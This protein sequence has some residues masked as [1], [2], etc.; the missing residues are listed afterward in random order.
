MNRKLLIFFFLS[1]VLEGSFGFKSFECPMNSMSFTKEQDVNWYT[2]YENVDS[3]KLCGTFCARSE[4]CLYWT[5]FESHSYSDKKLKTKDCL[6]FEESDQINSKSYAISGEKNCPQEVKPEPD[7]PYCYSP[8]IEFTADNGNLTNISFDD[9]KSANY[10]NDIDDV[11]TSEL[12]GQLCAITTPCVYWT[13]YGPGSP[14]HE[15]TCL[16]F[17]NIHELNY[18]EYAYSGNKYFPDSS[19]DDPDCATVVQECPD[20]CPDP[21]PDN[22][23]NSLQVKDKGLMQFLWMACFFAFMMAFKM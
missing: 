22:A 5:W 23:A 18:N 7:C 13:W 6:L 4:K 19:K 2:K 9:G 14:R 17:D 1:C 8:P 16:M 3:E 20:P 15:K 21:G 10:I 11:G 12:C